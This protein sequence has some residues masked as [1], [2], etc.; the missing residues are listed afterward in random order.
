MI[1][2]NR[3]YGKFRLTTELANSIK[4]QVWKSP[5]VNVTN[6]GFVKSEWTIKGIL[7]KSTANKVI[8]SDKNYD[9]R[10]YVYREMDYKNDWVDMEINVKQWKVPSLVR[11]FVI[12]NL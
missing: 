6:I 4:W 1:I 9:S 2:V 10:L 7:K 5:D 12:N 8:S 11:Y 3:G